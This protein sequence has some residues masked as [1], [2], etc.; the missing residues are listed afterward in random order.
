MFLT[1]D[2][3]ARAYAIHPRTLRAAARDG[4][5]QVSLSTRSVLGST[6]TIHEPF[7]S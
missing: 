3:L 4:R 5:L 2:V 7:R 1:L 6:A